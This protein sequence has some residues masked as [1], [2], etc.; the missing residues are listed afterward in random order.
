MLRDKCWIHLV[1]SYHDF[2]HQTLETRS[3]M[4]RQ[5]FVCNMILGF[6]NF[7]EQTLE[8]LSDIETCYCDT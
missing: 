7:T 4:L 3:E 8:T 2:T 6:L 1:K 5:A